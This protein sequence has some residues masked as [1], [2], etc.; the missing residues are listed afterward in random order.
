MDLVRIKATGV[1]PDTKSDFKDHIIGI[2]I[3]SPLT[4][5]C[6]YFTL[7]LTIFKAYHKFLDLYAFLTGSFSSSHYSKNVTLL[8]YV[9][10]SHT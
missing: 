6:V 10:L 7:L 1:D 9:S 4:T 3:F 8:G 2:A 5:N